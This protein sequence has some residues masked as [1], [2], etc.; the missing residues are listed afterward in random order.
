M[1]SRILHRQIWLRYRLP[2][3][4]ICA[5][6]AIFIAGCGGS[7]SS[8]SKGSTPTGN[9][10]VTVLAT[11]TAN[12]QIN[13]FNLD[14]KSLTLTNQS[15]TTVSLLSS[16]EQVEFI[17][18]NG[19]TEPLF[20]VSVP[21]DTYTS[22]TAIIGPA[23]FFCL[24]TDYLRTVTYGH[25]PDDNI[26]VNLPS[27]IQVSGANMTFALDLLVSQ[28]ASW[29]GTN[30]TSR[31]NLSDVSITP[32]FDLKA[33]SEFLASYASTKK[34]YGLA[35]Q[36]ASIGAAGNSFAVNAEDGYIT[37]VDTNGSYATWNAPVWNVSTNSDT[38]YEGVSGISALTAGMPVDMDATLQDDGSLLA[39]RIAVADTDTTILTV[40]TGP[41]SK[42]L[43]SQPSLVVESTTMYGYYPSMN[44]GMEYGA[45][46]YGYSDATFK[47]SS[48][49]S[50]LQQLPFTA[51]FD[52]SSLA[53]GQM[54]S[55]TWHATGSPN[56]PGYIPSA[57]ITLE[58]Q[59]LNGTVQSISS[60][61]D[62]D[63]YTISL[64]SYDLF[65]QLAVEQLQTTVLSDPSTVVVYVDK[66]AR[67][68]N[69]EPV[70]V[71]GVLR[72]N[73]AVFNDQGTLRMDC[74]QITDGVAE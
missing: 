29:G 14:L 60:S 23:Y 51:S 7:V 17:H 32:T 6:A 4:F 19:A 74:L 21:D 66:N 52:L 72:F 53:S 11:S 33:T 30:C 12:D 3:V 1:R 62:F 64:A 61:G 22:A 26:T 5:W 65:P 25:T 34:M 57:T 20:T 36:I 73:G 55:V 54:L 42:I 8:S 27:P 35:G 39:S 38:V 40:T 69:A 37:A 43:S 31:D 41:L 50:N 56:A 2:A 13:G 45:A 16:Y 18:L 68:L 24:G 59:T 44:Y 15:G 9:T 63:V 46:D 48:R 70:V 28:S 47:I 58:P 71:G 10:K 49:F 67:R